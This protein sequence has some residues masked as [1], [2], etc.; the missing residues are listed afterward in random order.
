MFGDTG[1]IQ[2]VDHVSIDVR[3]VFEGHQS[4]ELGG[5]RSFMKLD[6][7][8]FFRERGGSQLYF[9]LLQNLVDVAAMDHRKQQL[10]HHQHGKEH[11]PRTHDVW[12]RTLFLGDVLAEP[13]EELMEG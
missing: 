11:R 8:L 13:L 3:Q 6:E 9:V 5:A 10:L 2:K 1:V 7:D 12:E 4:P